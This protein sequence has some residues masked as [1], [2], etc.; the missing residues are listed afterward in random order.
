[1]T[2]R[3]Y[4]YGV[5]ADGTLT[6]SYWLYR[7][8]NEHYGDQSLL[9]QVSS[10]QYTIT[11]R[12]SK[13]SLVSPYISCYAAKSSEDGSISI[14]VINRH[15]RDSI[16]VNIVLKNYGAVAGRAEVYTLGGGG[17]GPMEDNAANPHNIV[18]Q[19]R[20]MEVSEKFLFLPD[21]VSVNII[22]IKP[23]H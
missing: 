21:P 19:A 11:T 2:D 4:T 23:A 6:P 9:V 8:L 13:E 15:T 5:I 1:M 17:K 14:M 7:M 10:P 18:P 3:K 22:V 16:P 12:G 20:S